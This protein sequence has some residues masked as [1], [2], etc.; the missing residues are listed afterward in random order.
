MKPQDG[1]APAKLDEVAVPWLPKTFQHVL[2][3][4]DPP[5]KV[6]M[7]DELVAT[8]GDKQKVELLKVDL[9]FELTCVDVC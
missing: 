4:I 6:A 7:R 5:S 2:F 1:I 3:W 9:H 8:R